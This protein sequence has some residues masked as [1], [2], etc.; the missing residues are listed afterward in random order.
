MELTRLEQFGNLKKKKKIGNTIIR[1]TIIINIRNCFRSHPF[2]IQNLSQLIRPSLQWISY[3]S[4]GHWGVVDLDLWYCALVYSQYMHS[5]AEDDAE[6][7][8]LWRIITSCGR[9]IPSPHNINTSRCFK[10][11]R[12]QF[13]NA[14]VLKLRGQKEEEELQGTMDGRNKQ[15]HDQQKSH[16]RRWRELRAEIFVWNE[17]YPLAQQEKFSMKDTLCVNMKTCQ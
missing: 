17:R 11:C 5:F 2:R 14:I 3:L 13:K 10:A 4:H 8:V 9:G 15:Q 1:M 7:R 6:D 16:R 12:D